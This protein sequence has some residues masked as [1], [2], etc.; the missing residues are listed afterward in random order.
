MING[1][2]WFRNEI[3]AAVHRI[4]YYYLAA[5]VRRPVHLSF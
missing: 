2:V 1:E 4:I 5:A 3:G